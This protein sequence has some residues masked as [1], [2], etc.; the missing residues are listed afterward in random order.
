M[1]HL[2]HISFHTGHGGSYETALDIFARIKSTF[3]RDSKESEADII[4]ALRKPRLLVIDEIGKRGESDWEN[5]V[6]FGLIDARY[7]DMTDTILIA[8][9]EPAAFSV[10]VG[11]SLADRMKETGGLILADWPSRR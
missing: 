1:K 5:N 4:A 7:R 3:R 9:L 2:D 11:A 10:C 6:F 8:N